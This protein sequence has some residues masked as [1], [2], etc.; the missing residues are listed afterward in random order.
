MTTEP[1]YADNLEHP[2]LT[3]SEIAL[4]R[5]PFCRV[6]DAYGLMALQGGR[7]FAGEDI[8]GKEVNTMAQCYFCG[9]KF[10]NRQGVRAHLKSCEAYRNRDPQSNLIPLGIRQ[11][12]Q[13]GLPIRQIEPKAMPKAESYDPASHVRRQFVEEK[14]ETIPSAFPL[15]E[16]PPPEEAEIEEGSKHLLLRSALEDAKE[17]ERRERIKHAR[18]ETG[19]RYAE[20]KAKRNSVSESMG[21]VHS[22]TGGGGSPKP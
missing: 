1:L 7:R 16:I 8:N 2:H 21:S 9:R 6:N 4:I 5:D 10:E 17:A 11:N 3:Q 15:D 13:A 18:I 19:K 22:D 14:P 20:E 12:L